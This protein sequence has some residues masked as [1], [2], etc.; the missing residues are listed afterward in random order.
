[1]I[2]VSFF[3][4]NQIRKVYSVIAATAAESLCRV[5]ASLTWFIHIYGE[6]EI[7]KNRHINYM[8]GS[9]VVCLQ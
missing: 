5:L 1:M 3:C 7:I 8:K 6:H 4:M 9:T 2:G